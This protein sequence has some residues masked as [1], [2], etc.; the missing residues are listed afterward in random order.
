ME[1][2][3]GR[4]LV[5]Q[6]G[7][8][9]AE[10]PKLRKKLQKNIARLRPNPAKQTGLGVFSGASIGHEF[11]AVNRQAAQEPSA[12]RR[13]PDLSD[14]KWSEYLRSSAYLCALDSTSPLFSEP[15]QLSPSIIPEFS[16]LALNDE[17]PRNSLD[18]L[19]QSS[20]SPT[21]SSFTMR[22]RAKTPV[23]SIGQLE[24][25]HLA[26]PRNAL[27]SDKRSSTRLMTEQS[28]PVLGSQ[29]SLLTDS[30]SE[31]PPSRHSTRSLLGVRRQHSSDG[32]QGQETQ[33]ERHSSPELAAELAWSPTSDDGTLVAFED[34]TVYFKP[35]SF[36]PEPLSPQDL[37][38]SRPV[39]SPSVAPDNLSLQI[40][41][42]LLMRDLSSGL[43]SRPNRSSPAAS[44]LQVWVMIE[45][46]E[47]LRDQLLDTKLRHD[48]LGPLDMMFDMWLRALYAIHDS[49][50]ESARSVQSDYEGLSS[51]DID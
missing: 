21:T 38:N 39:L 12:V 5:S 48:E 42:D 3:K 41:L 32:L 16:H 18:T 14:A 4:S 17:T 11:Y 20:S 31:P 50:T 35:V 25:Q 36:S 7:A 49:L 37:E 43:K 27:A 46:Y 30:H 33:P 24:A 22:R 28:Q 9:K 44:A 23:F 29:V 2:T 34:E 6:P 19:S 47:R 15:P 40:C 26:R 1:R 13:P 8:A 51:E 10:P 45:A